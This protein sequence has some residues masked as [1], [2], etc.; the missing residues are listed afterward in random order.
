MNNCLFPY[1]FKWIGAFLVLCGT[2]ALVFYVLYNL[3]F[4]VPVFAVFSSFLET[5]V[6]AII[7]TN[8][9]DELIMLAL[10]TGF[11]F[12]AFSKEKA[13][14]ESIAAIRASALSKAVF[15][16]TVFL[17]FSVLFIYG[18]GF[19]AMIL[20]NLVSPLIFYLVFFVILK[21]KFLR[22]QS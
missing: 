19:V 21:R 3:V 13:E 11:F 4:M 6:F 1:K 9:T 7:T 8:I 22:S 20:L 18:N 10:L 5:K 14:N 15:A 12:I 16:N 2:I 17:F